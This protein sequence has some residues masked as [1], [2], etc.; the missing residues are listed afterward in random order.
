MPETALAIM[1]SAQLAGLFDPRIIEGGLSSNE[2]ALISALVA[3]D[4]KSEV[5]LPE[6]ISDEALWD[7]L[8][9]CCKVESRVRKVQ[10]VLKML[11]GRALL[12]MQNR[13]AMYKERG[14]VSLDAIMSDQ[15][16]GLPMLTGI[17]RAELYNAK[18]IAKSWPTISQKDATEIGFTKLVT[19][20]KIRNQSDSDSGKWLDIAKSSTNEQLQD[21]I[22]RS[23]NGVPNGSLEIDTLT[24]TVT[25]AEKEEI[26]E[27]LK[28]PAYQAYCK[29]ALPGIMLTQCI[30]EST[31]EWTVQIRAEEDR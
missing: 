12:L 13:P 25:K 19:L 3:N 17:S 23:N 4:A 20:S 8:Q 31:V 2:R 21:A 18:T 24:I 29:S 5:V 26:E 9:V 1:P 27:F 14:F 7:A 28:N 10:T 6:S 22:Y 11:V 16:R 15:E 30:A